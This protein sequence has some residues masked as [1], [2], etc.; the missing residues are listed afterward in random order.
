MMNIPINAQPSVDINIDRELDKNWFNPQFTNIVKT[1]TYN[2]RI[3][4]FIF[5]TNNPINIAYKETPKLLDTILGKTLENN[6]PKADP[7]FQDK[8][9]NSESPAKNAGVNL[10]IF[11]IR[12]A[13][14]KYFIGNPKR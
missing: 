13:H 1:T 3:D 8:Y 14:R 10:L 9:E 4:F 2:K 11:F 7:T 12:H 6:I 5:G